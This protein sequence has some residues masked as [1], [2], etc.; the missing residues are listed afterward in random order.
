[1]DVYGTVLWKKYINEDKT[2]PIGLDCKKVIPAIEAIPDLY[3]DTG[4]EAW[5]RIPP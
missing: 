2:K 1:M 3:G 4:Y 5:K